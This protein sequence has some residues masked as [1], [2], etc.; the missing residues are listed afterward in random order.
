MNQS[1]EYHDNGEMMKPSVLNAFDIESKDHNH[2]HILSS[3]QISSNKLI[4]DHVGERTKLLSHKTPTAYDGSSYHAQQRS[5]TSSPSPKLTIVEVISNIIS[6]ITGSGMLSL[7]YAAK[8]MGWTAVLALLLIAASYIYTLNLVAKS[9]NFLASK[10]LY[11]H[12]DSSHHQIA[13]R[14]SLQLRGIDYLSLGTAVFGRHGGRLVAFMLSVELLLAMVSFFINIGLNITAVYTI[15]P[16]IGIVGATVIALCL[17]TFD[18]KFA[19]YSS[20][21]GI[22]MTMLVIIALVLSSVTLPAAINTSTG[23]RKYRIFNANGFPSSIGL[24]A[25]CFGGHGASPSIYTTMHEPARYPMALLIASIVIFSV[26]ALIMVV[27]YSTYAQYTLIPVTLNIGRTLDN[28]EDTRYGSMLRSLVG[29]GIIS[30]LQVTIP[31][32][33]YPLRELAMKSFALNSFARSYGDIDVMVVI[34]WSA[35]LI[36]AVCAIVLRNQ[37][38]AVCGFIGSIVTTLNSIILPIIFYQQLSPVQLSY[39]RRFMHLLLITSSL[40]LMSYGALHSLCTMDLIREH[41]QVCLNT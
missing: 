4:T 2:Q 8:S 29:L 1:A 33:S 15:D 17:C 14:G 13:D 7:P 28:D 31:L 22:A 27:G 25:F 20:A 11:Q 16:I 38:S 18:I 34:A 3:F 10:S 23:S 30:N 21:L 19:A 24:I 9:I 26:Y 12:I 36:S 41:L 5:S 32:V 39:R 37:L 6:L 40:C 35:I